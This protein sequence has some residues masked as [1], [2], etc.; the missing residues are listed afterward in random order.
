MGTKKYD[1]ITVK[2][3]AN[4]RLYDTSK[5]QYITL[6]DISEMVQ[7]GL[8]FI[9]VDAKTGEDLTHTVLAQIVLEQESLSPKMFPTDFMR[10]IIGMYGNGMQSYVPDILTQAMDT[11]VSNQEKLQ[12]QVTN[13]FGQ[14]GEMNKRSVEMVQ[15]AMSMFNPFIPAGEADAANDKDARIAALEKEIQ[16]LKKELERKKA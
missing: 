16:Q 9:V 14:F 6:K 1:K 11:L 12:S 10:K 13:S 15:S 5:S 7:E 3:Y 2:K 8:D 4:R